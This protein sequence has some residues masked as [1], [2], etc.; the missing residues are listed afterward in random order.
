MGSIGDNSPINPK[1]N[2]GVVLSFRKR[3]LFKD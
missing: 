3:L 1:N 2:A